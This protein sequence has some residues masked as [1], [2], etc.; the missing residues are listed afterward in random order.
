MEGTC[1]LSDEKFF[2]LKEVHRKMMGVSIG[3]SDVKV[4]ANWCGSSSI[5][6]ISAFFIDGLEM[7]FFCS[8]RVARWSPFWRGGGGGGCCSLGL[9]C[10]LFV[11]GCLWFWLFPVL[12]LGADFGFCLL[13]FLVV[14][15]LLHIQMF[16]V[17]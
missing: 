12:V 8:V 16:S 2:V 4:S 3:N 5:P 7:F 15:C 14:A 13:R 11:V 17:V 10:V 9:P 1:L 6:V